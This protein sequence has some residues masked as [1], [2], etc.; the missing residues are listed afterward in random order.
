MTFVISVSIPMG[1]KVA[2]AQTYAI[3][4]LGTLGGM[5]SHAYGLNNHGVIV[6]D[7]SL[8]NGSLHAF[9]YTNGMM[10]DLG[11]LGGTN[12][13]AY[14]V[15]DAG[16]VVGDADLPGGMHHGFMAT[17]G[18][19]M[20]DMG[21]L[22]GTNSV[23]YCINAMGQITGDGDLTNGLHH[24]FMSTNGMGGMMDLDPGDPA[25]TSGHWM[26][27]AGTVVGDSQL[28]TGN[29]HAVMMTT[30]GTGMMMNAMG[31]LGGASSTA[32]SIN[33]MGQIVGGSQL[34]N[35]T[36]HA[37]LAMPGMMGMVMSD[38]GTLG[39]TNSEA[40]CINP[41]GDVVGTTDMPDGSHHAFLYTG[42]MMRDLNSMIPG[43]N[44][45]QL[46]EARGIN[47][48]GQIVGSGM[49]GGQMH[50]F[51]MTPVSSPVQVSSWP[52]SM[53][54]SAGANAMFGVGMSGTDPLTYQWM[55]NGMVLAGQT[56]ASLV[57]NNVQ[58]GQAGKYH[59]VVS[60]RVGM[61]ASQS[62]VLTLIAL[63]MS[64]GMRPGL[65]INGAAGTPYRI[66]FT[67]SFSTSSPWLTLTNFT[68]PS[69]AYLY[70]DPRTGN[71]TMGFYRVV[72]GR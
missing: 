2:A 57:L 12:S 8:T 20:T 15:N 22:G 26:N 70:P 38:L 23:A 3:T 33:M 54:I 29:P 4:D 64:P 35:G 69:N 56:N 21:T 53:T 19:M 30:G 14:G 46:V 52:G 17:N 42:G 25:S 51:L 37:F 63:Q 24:A 72:P 36:A 48:V 43:T 34:T 6:G 27:G 5:D 55:L 28:G 67:A 47:D 9:M 40:F 65:M 16:Q 50:A 31:T 32:H 60:N 10:M 62:A 7:A 61:V 39:G 11:T 59:V 49:M 71:P 68:L 66:D 13:C 41:N 45:W 18:M 58:A 44:G 1:G